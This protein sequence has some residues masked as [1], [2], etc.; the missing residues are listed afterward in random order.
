[1]RVI[2]FESENIATIVQ[3]SKYE[4]NILFIKNVN[5]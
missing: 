1:M 2:Q 4:I 5:F 3:I